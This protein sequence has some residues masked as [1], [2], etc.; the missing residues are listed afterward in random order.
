MPLPTASAIVRARDE[1]DTIERTLAS[2]RAQSVPVE[3][4]VVD[5]GSRDGT[6][7]VARRWCDRLI[8]IDPADFTFGRA[9]NV[10]AA[11]AAGDVHYALSAHCEA[12][13]TDWVERALA[14]YREPDVAATNGALYSH[15]GIPLLEPFFMT[16]DDALRDPYWGH[17]N[18]ACSWRAATWREFPFD[19][20][21]EACED[22]EWSW[23]VLRAGWRIV[24]DP[25][26]YVSS[27]HVQRGGMRALYRRTH[28]EAR[29]MAARAD[30]PRRSAR[31]ALSQWWRDLP[32]DSAYPPLFHR[33]NYLRAAGIAARYAG[34]R[35]GRRARRGSD[36]AAGRV[37]G[38]Q[39]VPR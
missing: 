38:V 21:M 14:H 8:E 36:G 34:E 12:T 20:G 32:P 16:A 18:F 31:D 37:G 9:L 13:R 35:G 2:L 39:R 7:D 4:V 29:A 15:E 26:L 23:R 33:M 22:K 27:H 10:G 30:L 28:R 11:A 5:S 19:E 6:L 1:A 25:R 17:S 3:I 24:F